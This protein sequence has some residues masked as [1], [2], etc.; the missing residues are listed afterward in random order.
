VTCLLP[1]TAHQHQDCRCIR[2]PSA[3]RPRTLP[4]RPVPFAFTAVGCALP[5]MPRALVCHRA[6][7]TDTD[8]WL[9]F[10]R[11]LTTL[12][13]LPLTQHR[14]FTLPA[15][16]FV[17]TF[18]LTHWLTFTVTWWNV[19]RCDY[20]PLHHGLRTP[21]VSLLGHTV[22]PYGC[23]CLR[24]FPH[25]GYRRYHLPAFTNCPLLPLLNLTLFTTALPARMAFG[26]LRRAFTFP[27][28]ELGTLRCIQL[29]VAGCVR[30]VLPFACRLPWWT[31]LHGWR[32]CTFICPHRC[33]VVNWLPTFRYPSFPFVSVWRL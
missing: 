4:R 25:T 1:A 6:R 18:P 11:C 21:V 15:L 33:P 7:G 17:R 20:L 5:D 31:L 32:C 3:H 19:V 22:V 30:C 16:R 13:P 24:R 8:V 23:L 10:A 12:V 26:L 2:T 9:H 14:W 27:L 29:L 28:P